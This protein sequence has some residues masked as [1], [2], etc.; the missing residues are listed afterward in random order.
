M[1]SF[2]ICVLAGIYLHLF[3][4]VWVLLRI[5]GQLGVIGGI[6]SPMRQGL[7]NIHDDTSSIRRFVRDD[8]EKKQNAPNR[9]ALNKARQNLMDKG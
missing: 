3:I 8:W 4:V 1:S 6:L 5:R 7:L 2:E 9:K